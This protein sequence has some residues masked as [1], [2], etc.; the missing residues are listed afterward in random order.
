[1]TQDQATKGMTPREAISAMGVDPDEMLE[2]SKLARRA[3]GRSRTVCLCGHPTNSH[4]LIE[5]SGQVTCRPN[6]AYCPCE[7]QVPVL[8]VSDLRAFNRKTSGYGRRHALMAGMSALLERGDEATVVD[9]IVDV[10]CMSCGSEQGP[11]VPVAF[12]V[13][14]GRPLAVDHPS[15]RNTLLCMPCLE[16]F[17]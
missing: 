16:R 15:P 6:R 7:E 14:G 10:K 5:G 8:Q 9:W 1:V 11:I 2:Y 12:I 17:R 4:R 13:D 3:K